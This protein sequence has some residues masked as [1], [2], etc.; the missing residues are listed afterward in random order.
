MERTFGRLRTIF[1]ALFAVLVGAV[2]VYHW[3][4]EKPEERCVERKAWWDPDTRICAR[5]VFLA[6]ITGRPQGHKRTPEQVAAARAK[7]KA[8]REA[9]AR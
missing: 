6:D 7:L 3:V 1:L 4:W 5:P 2:L 9:Q 8:S